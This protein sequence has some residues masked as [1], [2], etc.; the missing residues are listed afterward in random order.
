LG[1]QTHNPANRPT[2]L[3]LPAKTGEPDFPVTPLDDGTNAADRLWIRDEF[4]ISQVHQPDET[5]YPKASV[6]S[7]A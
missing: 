4:V 2:V 1:L 7:R 6:T 3:I 5:A